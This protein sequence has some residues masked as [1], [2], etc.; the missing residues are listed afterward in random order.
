MSVK[1]L[2]WISQLP[3]IKV[4]ES[5]RSP[6]VVRKNDCRFRI[7]ILI[8]AQLSSNSFKRK[9]WSLFVKKNGIQGWKVW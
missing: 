1:F 7:S 3:Y 4:M 5:M 2:F 6:T 8:Y 9:T